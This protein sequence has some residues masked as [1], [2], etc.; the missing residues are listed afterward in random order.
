MWLFLSGV[1]FFALCS[2][3]AGV[4]LIAGM[5]GYALIS[6]LIGVIQSVILTLNEKK[7]KTDV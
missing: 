6:L 1:L 2:L 5:P 3:V 4:F 7:A